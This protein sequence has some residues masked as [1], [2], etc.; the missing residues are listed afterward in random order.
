MASTGKTGADAIFL[1]L[2]HICR[3]I[4]RYQSKL[5]AVVVAAE[6]AGAITP[7]QATTITNFIATAALAC[8]AFEALA[9]YSGF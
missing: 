1:A 8:S 2:R 7:T 6:N 9:N 3:I 4:T 5:N